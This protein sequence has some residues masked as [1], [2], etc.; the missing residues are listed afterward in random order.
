M[1]RGAIDPEC[2]TALR[3]AALFH[4]EAPVEVPIIPPDVGA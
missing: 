2:S 1:N 3:R 4:T